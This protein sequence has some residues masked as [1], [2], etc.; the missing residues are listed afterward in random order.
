MSAPLPTIN[1]VKLALCHLSR[2]WSNMTVK[3]HVVKHTHGQTPF[4][5]STG[6]TTSIDYGECGRQEVA[7]VSRFLFV[8]TRSHSFP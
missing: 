5:A 3:T 8:S 4:N 2:Y 1:D 6:R 7:A